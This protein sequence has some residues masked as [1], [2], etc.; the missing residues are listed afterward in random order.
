MAMPGYRLRAAASISSGSAHM[1]MY[2]VAR[3]SPA[4]PAAAS[5]SS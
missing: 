4:R 1:H 2:S 5:A 3:S